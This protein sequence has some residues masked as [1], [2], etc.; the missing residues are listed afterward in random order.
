M[1]L[2]VIYLDFHLN[3]DIILINANNGYILNKILLY[4]LNLQGLSEG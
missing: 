4:Y 1:G 3:L 2:V